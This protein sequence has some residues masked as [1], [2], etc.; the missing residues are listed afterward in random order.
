MT[1]PA[2]IRALAT[3][4]SLA[5]TAVAT[6]S[7]ANA[8]GAAAPMAG[9]PTVGTCSTMTA[10]QAAARSDH[11]TVVG[12]SKP[13]TAQVAGVVKLPSRLKWDEASKRD[14]Y[15]VIASRCLPKFAAVLGRNTRARD[16]SAYD[17][18][19]F[20]PTKA[21]IAQGARWLSC[22]V[23][24]RRARS[25]ANLPTSSTPF[26]PDGKLPGKVA[27]CLTKSALTTRCSATH[28]WRATGAFAVS[29]AYPGTKK[30]NNKANEK[31]RSRVM[32]GKPYRWTYQDKITWN[33][34][35]DHVVVCYSETRR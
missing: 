3:A 10:A 13:H 4:A 9:A 20:A 30:L 34:G 2:T 33:V 25:L 26:L 8:G 11:S 18:L 35:G 27:R 23:E 22:S 19:W 6:M 16:S 14:L 24:L 21:Q 32:P 12:C 5:L 1:I 15:R 7:P 17:L 29:G 31:C 28:R